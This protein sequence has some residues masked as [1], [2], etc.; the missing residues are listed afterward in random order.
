MKEN[1][2]VKFLSTRIFDSLDEFEKYLK[3]TYFVN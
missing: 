2:V 3:T 1:W